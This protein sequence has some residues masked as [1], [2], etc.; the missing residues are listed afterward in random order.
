[1][2]GIPEPNVLFNNSFEKPE[3]LYGKGEDFYAEAK[4]VSTTV[5]GARQGQ[6]VYWSANFVPDMSA[7]DKLVPFWGRGAGGT[8]V[9]I[10]FPGTELACHMSVFDPQLYKKG[11]RHGPGRVIV[12]PKGEGYSVLWPGHNLEWGPVEGAEKVVCPWSEGTIF[13]PPQNWYHQ[14][15]NTGTGEARYLALG[16]LPQFGGREYHHQI[17][18]PFEDPW[19]RERFESEIAKHGMK[20]LMPDEAYAD[21]KY[22]WAYGDDS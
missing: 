6:G 2:S 18:Y 15:F 12:I 20:S 11:H 21:P 1:M 16:P 17:E 7:W 9:R 3:L 14:H 10:R 22:E 19:I 4:M 5:D 8:V 13:V